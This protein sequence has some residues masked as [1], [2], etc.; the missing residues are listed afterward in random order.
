MLRRRLGNYGLLLSLVAIM[1]FFQ[2]ATGG[3]LLQPLNI[4]NL[5]LQ[6]SYVVIMALGMLMVI[7]CGHI[8]LSVGSVAGF[9]GALAGA[10]MVTHQM[11]LVPAV[12]LCLVAGAAAGAL[13][14]YWVAYW[15]MPSFI[16]TL[17]GMLV[18]RGV[19]I[20]L[21][22]GASVGP[23]PPLF[24]SISSGFLPDP[25]A[26]HRLHLLS[27]VIGTL[28]TLAFLAVEVRARARSLSRGATVPS[29][30]VFALR[31]G[32]V[33]ALLLVFC[34]TLASYRGIPTVMVIMGVLIAFYTFLMN[35]T[36][37][38]RRIYAVGGNLKA[39]RLSGVNTERV[40][41]VAFVNMG[42]LAAVAGLIFAARLNSATPRAGTGFELDV[43]AAVF[44]GG[45]SASGGAGKVLGVVIGAFIMGVLNNGMSIL[46]LGVDYQQMIKGLVLLAAVFIDIYQKNKS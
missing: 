45:A 23:F 21:S 25:F 16:V 31:N 32:T 29:L 41:F 17:A 28:A 19:T 42:L 30:S 15:R 22:D 2:Y 26:T 9:V 39:A 10:L 12:V 38:G 20:A 35:R 43:I 6:N 36:V 4:T 44:I 8:D 24:T 7:V 33:A 11:G 18:F 46:G 13:Q 40:A 27:L 37:L 34:Y 1:A 14:G 5:L 3:V